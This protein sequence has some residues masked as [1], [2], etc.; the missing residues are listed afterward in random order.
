MFREWFEIILQF[1]ALLLYGGINIFNFDFNSLS[2]ETSVV[3]TFAVI[4]SLNCILFGILLLCYV[5]K[6]N[7][8][9]GYMFISINFASDTVFE[10]MYAL[11]PLIYLTSSNSI[12]SLRSLGMYCI[13]SV[14]GVCTVL[15][16][17]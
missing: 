6:F 10:F 7:I 12:F 4:I 15:S 14:T 13:R 8:F 5:I 16:V 3:V 2:Q 9:Y 1:S 11:F 17:S